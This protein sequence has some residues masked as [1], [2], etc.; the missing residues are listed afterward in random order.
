MEIN[1]TKGDRIGVF[2]P[3]GCTF[4]EGNN[5]TFCPSQVN[6]HANSTSCMSALYYPAESE[7]TN[8]IP[9]DSFEEVQ[10]HL[11][12]EVVITQAIGT[13]IMLVQM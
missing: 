13:Y 12:V 9:I 8:N 1:V 7:N 11:N 6:L 10:V 3:H 2:I 5:S 4:F